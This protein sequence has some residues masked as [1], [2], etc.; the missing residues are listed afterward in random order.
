M[1]TRFATRATAL[2]LAALVTF[3][4]LGSVDALATSEPHAAVIAAASQPRA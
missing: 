4:M 3:A 2:S 1:F